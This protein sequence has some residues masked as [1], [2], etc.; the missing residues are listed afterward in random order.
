MSGEEGREEEGK[1]EN[2]DVEGGGDKGDVWDGGVVDSVELN[3]EKE[4]V[5]FSVLNVVKSGLMFIAKG[6]IW[7]AEWMESGEQ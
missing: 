4:D 3:D 6:D 5:M 2:G 1:G 7:E